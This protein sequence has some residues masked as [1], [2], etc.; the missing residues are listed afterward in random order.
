MCC[1]AID[2]RSWHATASPQSITP[3]ATYRPIAIRDFSARFLHSM[4]GRRFKTQSRVQVETAVF[5]CGPSSE[6]R[7]S[8]LQG[9][10]DWTRV[11]PETHDG[12]CRCQPRDARRPRR[13]IA[14]RKRVLERAVDK[15]RHVRFTRRV[16]RAFL[17]LRHQRRREH[18]GARLNFTELDISSHHVS[19]P[20]FDEK[21][22]KPRSHTAGALSEESRNGTHTKALQSGGDLSQ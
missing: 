3:F 4:A 14:G 12:A 8:P 19:Q 20:L 5:C 2:S 9:P 16:R 10:A 13:R 15:L 21:R 6:Q 22:G 1:A 18:A 17:L 11:S 7:R